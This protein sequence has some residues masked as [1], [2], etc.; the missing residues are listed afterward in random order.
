[1]RANMIRVRIASPSHITKQDRELSQSPRTQGV[2]KA[3]AYIIAIIAERKER[4][5]IRLRSYRIR[6]RRV[7]AHREEVG[8]VA[9]VAVAVAAE[10]SVEDRRAAAVRAEAGNEFS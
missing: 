1:M 9:A 2:A 8:R 3:C 10:A 7:A 5:T 4:K 6:V